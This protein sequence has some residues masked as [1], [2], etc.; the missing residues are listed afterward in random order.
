M[1]VVDTQLPVVVRVFRT[2][3]APG[4]GEIAVVVTHLVRHHPV[5]RVQ[6]H[7]VALQPRPL[8][9][10]PPVVDPDCRVE[11]QTVPGVLAVQGGRLRLTPLRPGDLHRGAAGG[12]DVGAGGQQVGGLDPVRPIECQPGVETFHTVRGDLVSQAGGR[13]ANMELCVDP[14]PFL[15]RVEYEVV[16]TVL[17]S[18]ININNTKHRPKYCQIVITSTTMT[19]S[20][21]VTS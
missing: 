2:D 14:L 16:T 1:L 21:L 19:I 8:V 4:V 3:G 17:P 9:E 5:P 6:E 18:H 12:G 20:D 7:E 13:V 15:G 11:P 10:I